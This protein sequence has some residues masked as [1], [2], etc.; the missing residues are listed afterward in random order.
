MLAKREASRLVR[1][2][3][4]SVVQ[5]VRAAREPWAEDAAVE[6]R[7]PRKRAV[8]ELEQ[9]LRILV[10]LLLAD[11]ERRRI[12]AGRVVDPRERML[13]RR[14]GLA[15][16][17]I[18]PGRGSQL[19]REVPPDDADGGRDEQRRRDRR[20]RAE[21]RDCHEHG[22]RDDEHDDQQDANE[23][24]RPRE[25]AVALLEDREPECV[26]VQLDTHLVR[27]L[28]DVIERVPD[29][30][31]GVRTGGSQAD[32]THAAPREDERCADE[33]ERR[34]VDEVSLLDARRERG[35]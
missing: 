24:R 18:R 20:A 23:V 3:E 13:E 15:C 11:V 8:P 1:P 33:E 14:S 19:A 31:E 26:R 17:R 12:A 30:V 21:K 32:P 16:D 9:P 29:E 10:V 6:A 25:V 22:H 27:V 34:D 5:D 7:D 4:R 28:R 2:V 35:G